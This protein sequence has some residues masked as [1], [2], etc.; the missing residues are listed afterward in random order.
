M[1]LTL[2]QGDITTQ[3]VDAVVNAANARMRGGGGVDGAIHAA[4]G[5]AILDDCVHRFPRGLPTGQAG[6]TTA[7]ELPAEW[8][9]HVVGPNWN[10]G[11]RDP[12]LLASC[13]RNALTVADELSARTVAFPA[14]SAGIYGWP[15]ADAARIAV[16]TV[17]TA[18]SKVEEAR[19]VLFS[20][21]ILAAFEAAAAE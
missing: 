7:G 12:A 3:Q 20:K 6:W 13:Y 18:P 15:L 14:V 17:R 21:E 5:P 16:S 19:F 11:Q 1:R 8:V 2:I 4:G 9:I 10:A